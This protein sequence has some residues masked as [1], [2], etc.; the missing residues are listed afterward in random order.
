MSEPINAFAYHKIAKLLFGMDDLDESGKCFAKALTLFNNNTDSGDGGRETMAR[1]YCSK[2]W[3]M[4]RLP[5]S[6]LTSL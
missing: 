2:T 4:T 6:A 3:V 1:A 5:S